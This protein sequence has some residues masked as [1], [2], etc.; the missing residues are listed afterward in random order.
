VPGAVQWRAPQ[1]AKR[2]GLHRLEMLQAIAHG[3]DGTCY[4]QFR[5]G[6]GSAEKL[7]GAVIEHCED[8]R[9]AR[10]RRYRG[11]RSLSDTYAKLAPVLGT[12]V[13]PEVAVVYDWA[14]KWGQNL[15]C[16]TGMRQPD[17]NS[18]QLQYFDE[19]A[20]EHYAN[21]WK[22]GIPVDVISNDRDFASYKLLV[23]P[24]HWIMTPAVAKKLRDYV[25]GGGTVV[26]TWDTA[27]ADEHNRMLP[28]GWAGAGLEDVFGL[29][30]EEADRLPRA[31]LVRSTDYPA[32]ARKSRS[33]PTCRAPG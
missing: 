18:G 4:F 14:S 17:W 26:A 21:F 11:L 33:W 22:R 19:V 12:S 32:P 28:G 15:S 13:R 1:K 25:A 24:M 3:A 2:P 6:R 20:A 5:P 31:R 8:H 10:T 23:L 27:M 16:G 9:H 30:T 29:W 7:H